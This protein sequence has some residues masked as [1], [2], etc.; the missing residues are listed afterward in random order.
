ML[1]KEH[2]SL[3]K[4]LRTRDD[5]NK[6]GELVLSLSR[7]MG[8]QRLLAMVFTVQQECAQWMHALQVRETNRFFVYL[9]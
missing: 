3:Q 8:E 6:S 4:Y 7:N 2:T 1:T 9:L 5:E